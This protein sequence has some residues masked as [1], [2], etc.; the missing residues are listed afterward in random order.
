MYQL[1]TTKGRKSADNISTLAAW[2]SM[3][4]PSSARIVHGEMEAEIDE[5]L[6]PSMD[7]LDVDDDEYEASVENAM[8]WA[9][10]LE[11]AAALD[12]TV[13]NDNIYLT[14]MGVGALVYLR[15][16]VDCVTLVDDRAMVSRE[17]GDAETLADMLTALQRG[18]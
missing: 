7:G 9:L 2:Y 17:L 12:L 1:I 13:N 11:E 18:E 4:Q 6:D 16:D 5:H 14:R 15:R 8:R 10:R 3:M